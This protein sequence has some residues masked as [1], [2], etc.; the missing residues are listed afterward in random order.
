[1]SSKEKTIIINRMYAGSYLENNLGHEIINTFKTDNGENYIYINAY[2]TIAKKYKDTKYVLLV[3]LVDVH[4]FEVIGYA[5]KLELL[6]SDKAINNTQNE[7]HFIDSRLQKE[8]INNNKVNYGGVPVDKLFT[9]KTNTIFLTYRAKEYKSVKKNTKLFIV[10][11]KELADKNHIYIPNFKF[12]QQSLKMYCK[13]DEKVEAYKAIDKLI[14]RKSLWESKNTSHK[15]N[16]KKLLTKNPQFIDIVKQSDN[17]LLFS[18][19]I[20]YYLNANNDLLKSFCRS[21]LGINVHPSKANVYREKHNIDILI[22]DDNNLIVIENKI[23]S[24]ING[25]DLDRHDIKRKRVKSQL[26]TYIKTIQKESKKKKKNAYYFI[27]LPDYSYRDED[28][29]PYLIYRGI[30]YTV[31]RYST[32]YKFFNRFKAS[33]PFYKEFKDA[34]YKHSSIIKNDLYEDMEDSFIKMILKRKASK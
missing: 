24:G 26:T 11:K 1:M 3:R 31:I 34:V 19:W 10:D 33:E 21:V 16:T 28:L 13:S 14:N 27:L 6:L 8:I 7:A 32:L 5:G 30:T 17:E 4:T 12:S 18:N 25:V 15:I 9:E 2:G 29:D 23:R 22:E 20:A